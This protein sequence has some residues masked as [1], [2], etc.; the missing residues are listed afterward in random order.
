MKST[1]VGILLISLLCFVNTWTEA[2][3]TTGSLS[4]G[5]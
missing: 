1:F 2:E 4:S 3:G 5:H